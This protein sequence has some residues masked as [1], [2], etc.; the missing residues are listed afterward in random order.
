MWARSRPPGPP[1]PWLGRFGLA[2]LLALACAL[3]TLACAPP[4]LAQTPSGNWGQFRGNPRLTGAAPTAPPASLKLRWVYE[5]GE[6]IESSAAIVDGGVY[7]GSSKGELLAID[8]ESGKL[9]WK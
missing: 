8:L 3:P 7:V 4:A 5:A 1:K 6:S 9:R 2:V